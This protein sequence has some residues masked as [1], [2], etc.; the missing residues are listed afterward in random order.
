MVRDWA[1]DVPPAAERLAAAFWPG[2]LTLILPRAAHVLD[3]VTGG[4]DSVGLRV[5][6]HPVAHQL[7]AA[8]GDGVVAPSANRFGRISAT[9]A[10]H[11]RAEMGDAV[12]FVLDGGATDVGVESTIVALTG[13]RPVLLRPGGI[14]PAQIAAV[15]GAPPDE[16][17]RT[18]PRASGTLPSHYA[19][20]TPLEIVPADRLVERATCLRAAGKRIGVLAHS[21][22]QA[23]ADATGWHAMPESPDAYAHTL[24]TTLRELDTLGYDRILVEA[25]PDGDAWLAIRDR[26]HRAAAPRP[27]A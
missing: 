19:P 24:Y 11:V 20:R 18:A 12:D 9:R 2:P 6:S 5:P 21:A 15:L 27:H 3:L 13:E 25:V 8:F 4:Q 14:T 16:P 23:S 10:E 22:A 7:L 1:R 26:L 17:N